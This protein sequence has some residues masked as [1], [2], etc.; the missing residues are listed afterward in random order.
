MMMHYSPLKLAEVF[1]TLSAFTP[2]RI[3]FGVGRAPGGDTSAMYAL[4]EGRRLMLHNMYD[5][6]AVTM[7][8]S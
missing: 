3:D 8:P 4:S 7:R 6:L 1:K 5:K 2:G